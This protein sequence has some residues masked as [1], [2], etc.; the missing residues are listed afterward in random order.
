MVKIWESDETTPGA[1]CF[2]SLFGYFW[3]LIHLVPIPLPVED[4]NCLIANL[5]HSANP[6]RAKIFLILTY[7]ATH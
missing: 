6:N 4:C 7:P 2:L 1:S 3:V 5:S